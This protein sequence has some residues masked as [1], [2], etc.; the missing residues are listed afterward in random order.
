VLDG[1]GGDAPKG[2]GFGVTSR[3]DGGGRGDNGG[4]ESE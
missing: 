4:S 3:K 2:G 1:G